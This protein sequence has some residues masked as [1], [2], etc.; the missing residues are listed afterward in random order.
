MKIETK[1]MWWFTL[2]LMAGLSSLTVA[3]GSVPKNITDDTA[4][5]QGL[6]EIQAQKTRDLNFDGDIARLTSLE[7]RYRERLPSLYGRDRLQ[8]PMKRIQGQRYQYRARPGAA[9]VKKTRASR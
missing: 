1:K 6:S 2:G 3:M 7:S 9:P 8:G 5:Y 4:L